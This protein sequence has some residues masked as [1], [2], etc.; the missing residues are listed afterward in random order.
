MSVKTF[1]LLNS[2]ASSSTYGSL[3]DGGS[4]TTATTTTGWT[5]GTTAGTV[6]ANQNYNTKVTAATFGATPQ[7]SAAPANAGECWRSSNPLTGHFESGTW[8]IA[9]SVIASANAA[10]G[11]GRLRVRIWKSANQNGSSAVELTTSTISTTQWNN[12][13]TGAAQNLTGSQAIAATTFANEYLFI[14]VACEIDTASGNAAADVLIRIDQTNSKLTTALF[15]PSI[16]GTEYPGVAPSVSTVKIG[17]LNGAK[18]NGDFAGLPAPPVS[19]IVV[20]NVS[21]AAPSQVSNTTPIS[22]DIIDSSVALA[23]IIIA[24]FYPGLKLYEVVYD[25]TK[26]TTSYYNATCS[27][28]AIPHGFHFSLMRAPVWPDAPHVHIFAAAADGAVL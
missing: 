14:E 24:V 22:F 17:G 8:T 20:T 6:Y 15:D 25:G 16:D 3:Q 2:A 27:V 10:T 7:P 13:T 1:L 23:Q 12:L 11:T 28:T 26:F 19:Q 18:V 4:T 21:P 9:I 5:V